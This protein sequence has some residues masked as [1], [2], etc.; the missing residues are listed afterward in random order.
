[1]GPALAVES[2]AFMLRSRPASAVP[3]RGTYREEGWRRCGQMS[4]ADGIRFTPW[5]HDS[6]PTW[7]LPAH[8]AAKCVARQGEASFSRVH[9]RLY[10]AFFT[11]SRDIADRDEL[12]RIVSEVEGVD[13]SRFRD[14]FA[15]GIGREIAVAEHEA[16]VEKAGVQAIPAV[17]VEATGRRL[18]G[19]AETAIYRQAI[20]EA[21][22]APAR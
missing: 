7:S 8:E 20:A 6:L 9:L 4:A 2:R 13:V 16:A 1:M 18:V 15:A 11:E 5:P 17:I 3:F 10:E 22:A 14:D 19:L 12:T 21:G